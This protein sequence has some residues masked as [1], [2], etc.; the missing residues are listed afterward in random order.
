M[1]RLDA[2]TRTHDTYK[3]ELISSSANIY[4]IRPFL[5]FTLRTKLPTLTRVLRLFLL[6]LKL[7]HFDVSLKR[8]FPFI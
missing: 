6:G 8:M 4:D 7:K 3:T 5:P 1:S 2:D